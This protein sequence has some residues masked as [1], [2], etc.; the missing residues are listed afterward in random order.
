MRLE[1]FIVLC[2]VPCA[3]VAGCSGDGGVSPDVDATGELSVAMATWAPG[4]GDSCTRGNPRHLFS[5]VGPDGLRYPTWHPPTDPSGCPFGHEHGRDPRGSDL[6]DDVGLMPFGLCQQQLEI[7]DPRNPRNED[8]VGHKVEWENDVHLD[9]GD[10]KGGIIE[11]TCDVL[12]KLHQGTHS[13]DAFTNNLH[14]LIYHIRCSDRTEMHITLMTAIGTPGEFVVSAPVTSMWSWA[15]PRRAIRRAAGASA[16][17]RIAAA[18]IVS[19][20]WVLAVNRT[21]SPRCTKAGRRTARS[22]LPNGHALASFDPYFQVLF[23]SRFY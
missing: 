17:C 23:P 12:A 18:S 3:L 7:F 6:F 5:T 19:C 11:V 1:R 14:E 10:G 4:A 20:L 13:K 2:S 9:F 15:R 8:H 16:S 21:S 22:R